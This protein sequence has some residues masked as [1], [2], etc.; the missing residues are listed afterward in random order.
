MAVSSLAQDHN[1][2]EQFRINTSQL[3]SLYVGDLD[4]KVTEALLFEKFSRAGQILSIRV[5][6]DRNLRTSLG[7]A[8]INFRDHESADRAMDTLNFEPMFGKPMRI[9]WSIRDPMYRRHTRSNIFIRNLGRTVDSKAVHDTFSL[10]GQIMSCKVSTNNGKNLG[11]AFVHFDTEAAANEAIE[12]LNGM[13]LFGRQIY[14]GRFQPRHERHRLFG[15]PADKFSNVFVKNF[16]DKWDQPKLQEMF[17]AF[18]EITSCV[19]MTDDNGVSKGF[20][21]VAYTNTENAHAAVDGMNGKLVEGTD[22]I[23]VVCR[24]QPKCERVIEL[25]KKHRERNIELIQKYKGVNLY[26]KNLD[27]SVDDEQLHNLFKNF[28]TI[29]SAKIMCEDNGISRG[30]GFVCFEKPEEAT[31]AVT[32]MNGK[33][34]KS[35]PLYV[36][37]AQRK[38]ERIAILAS[39]FV[40]NMAQQRLQERLLA[41]QVA[42][43]A[44]AAQAARFASQQSS[45][46]S[47]MRV[48]MMNAHPGQHAYRSSASIN[49]SGNHIYPNQF[50]QPGLRP[51]YALSAPRVFYTGPSRHS[52]YHNNRYVPRGHRYNQQYYQRQNQIIIS[53]QAPLT[54]HM[55]AQAAPQEQK[56]LLGERIY[57]LIEKKFPQYKETGKLTGMML[58]MD[59]SEFIILLQDEEAFRGKLAEAAAVL[60]GIR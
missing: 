19:V 16:G 12:K 6:R 23:L 31:N 26:V 46:P 52:N 44:Q 22:N 39:K 54:S 51:P 43:A 42:Q 2:L 10:L 4:P 36:A 57:P 28:G 58:E 9:M 53:G 5:C 17:S 47:Y 41:E 8:Y 29:T 15:N 30:F 59:N 3:A 60:N 33:M 27:I 48:P 32:E 25:R 35:K 56:Q 50:N 20:G 1:V 7:Y 18:G 38:A 14:V 45:A 13:L 40:Q 37:L 24:A 11:H 34:V 55:L 49:Y 21:F